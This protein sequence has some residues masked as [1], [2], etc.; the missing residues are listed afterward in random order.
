MPLYVVHLVRLVAKCIMIC[1]GVGRCWVAIHLIDM[2]SDSTM[3]LG[4]NHRLFLHRRHR[5]VIYR[6]AVRNL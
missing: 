4:S 1:F 6:G 5:V 2:M 3:G